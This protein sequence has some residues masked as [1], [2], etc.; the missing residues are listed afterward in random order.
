MPYT[1]LDDCEISRMS[2][3]LGGCM[4]RTFS[5]TKLYIYETMAGLMVGNLPSPS[6]HSTQLPDMIRYDMRN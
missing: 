4:R 3:E 2:T 1:A 6:I 5:G